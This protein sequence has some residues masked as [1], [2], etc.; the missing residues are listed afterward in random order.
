MQWW[1]HDADLQIMRHVGSNITSGFGGFFVFF[2]LFFFLLGFKSSKCTYFGFFWAFCRSKGDAKVLPVITCLWDLQLHKWYQV[3]EELL[4]SQGIRA[5]FSIC[6]RQWVPRGDR[7]MLLLVC[8]NILC[9]SQCTCKKRS[10]KSMAEM[11]RTGIQVTSRIRK[12]SGQMEW[13]R[14]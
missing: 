4:K 11:W 6:S 5:G 1:Y 13:R 3:S 2:L 9:N 10:H 8:K 12:D 14:S 7:K